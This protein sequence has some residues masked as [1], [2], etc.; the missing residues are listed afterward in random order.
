MG[1]TLITGTE[2]S[3][4]GGAITREVWTNIS[5]IYVSAIPLTTAF[6]STGT[7]S[8]LEGP[9]NWADN[10]GTRLRGYITAP[11]TVTYYFWI[12]GDDNSELW[13]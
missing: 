2:P 13:L 10:Y 7:L 9:Q 12:A 5:G 8:S 1:T 6:N 3:G 4:G 11:T